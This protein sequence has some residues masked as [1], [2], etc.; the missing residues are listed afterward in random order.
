M[1]TTERQTATE[2]PTQADTPD[3]P[4]T[5]PEP[6]AQE[7]ELTR[8]EAA[9]SLG[10]FMENVRGQGTNLTGLFIGLLIAAIVA[11]Q[12]FIPVVNDAIAS[13]NVSGTTLTILELLSLFASLLLLI[14]LASPLMRRI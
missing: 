11:I 10:E 12:V 2:A 8:E 9:A 7:A 1:T 3:T 6:R 4:E 14:A 13:S 5:P